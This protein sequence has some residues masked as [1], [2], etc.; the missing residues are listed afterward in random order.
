MN[1]FFKSS[2]VKPPKTLKLHFDIMHYQFWLEYLI[3]FITLL[4]C[5]NSMFICCIPMQIW[6]FAHQSFYYCKNI[7]S[8]HMCTLKI[9]SLF[10]VQILFSAN[11]LY[12]LHGFHVFYFLIIVLYS[13]IY[14]RFDL[15]IFFLLLIFFIPI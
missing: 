1:T 15:T 14:D 11:F 9:N 8:Y 3:V 6:N 4:H 7:Y 5:R 12:W 13:F 10:L 2:F